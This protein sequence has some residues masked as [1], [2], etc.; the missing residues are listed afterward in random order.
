MGYCNRRR[1]EIQSI[2]IHK[3][4]TK[5]YYTISPILS[6]I[7]YIIAVSVKSI[8]RYFAELPKVPTQSTYKNN[9]LW[10]Q[11]KCS[12]GIGRR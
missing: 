12:D 8:Y 5:Q 3:K 9:S 11:Q 6:I 7:E 2:K 4:F 1:K 10:L